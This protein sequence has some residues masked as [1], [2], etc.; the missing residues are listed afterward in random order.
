MI[1]GL[2]FALGAC[3]TEPENIGP[4]FVSPALYASYDCGQIK[5]ELMRVSDDVSRITGQQRN[6]ANNDKW[7]AGVGIVI[8]WPALFF[9]AVGDK[10]DQLAHLKGEYDALV[11]NAN[12]KK[13]DYAHDLR[14]S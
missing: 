12:E 5:T 11:V 9:L 3:A 1:V 6:K 10:Q 7:A 14:P 4:S 8:F 13:C 2:T